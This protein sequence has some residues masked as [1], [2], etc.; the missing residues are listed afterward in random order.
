MQDNQPEYFTTD[1]FV[2]SEAGLAKVLTRESEYADMAFITAFR[3]EIPLAENRRRN[4]ELQAKIKALGL[5]ACHLIGHWQACQD[6]TVA[7]KDCPE[8]APHDSI[9]EVFMLI[10]RTDVSRA[11]FQAHVLSFVKEYGQECALVKQDEFYY[12]HFRDGTQERNDDRSRFGIA[13][14]YSQHVKKLNVPF[15]FEGLLVPGC[16][17]GYRIASSKGIAST[18]LPGLLVGE[19]LSERIER[20]PKR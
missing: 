5:V 12:L 2:I 16:I 9:E 4:K 11:D 1:N 20:L 14:A 15:V 19:M 6:S 7:Y 8:N 18:I 17:S 13:Q 3:L 10:K